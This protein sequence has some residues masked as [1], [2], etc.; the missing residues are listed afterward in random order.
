MHALVG[1]RYKYIRYH[2]IWD[3][4]ELFDLEN[5]PDEKRNLINDPGY[6]ELI[7]ELNTKLF[8]VLRNTK[9]TEM[10]ILEDRGTK[11]L[12]RKDQ[13]TRGADFPDWFYREP[14]PSWQP[15]K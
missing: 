13:G 14:E 6:Q 2:G 15:G 4:D 10:P 3:I 12:H 1:K 7:S 9:G 11:F 5:D 8:E